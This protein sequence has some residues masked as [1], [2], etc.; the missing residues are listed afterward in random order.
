MVSDS[1]ICEAGLE[2]QNKQTKTNVRQMLVSSGRPCRERSMS[3]VFWGRPGKW[4][5]RFKQNKT[6]KCSSYLRVLFSQSDVPAGKNVSPCVIGTSRSECGTCLPLGKGH[7]V[8]SGVRQAVRGAFVGRTC[9]VGLG[10]DTHGQWC[11]MK[12]QDESRILRA[13]NLKWFFPP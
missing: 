5:A 1:S 2:N 9:W 12:W 13:L 8:A 6:T 7:R 4:V 10:E 3:M 11:A